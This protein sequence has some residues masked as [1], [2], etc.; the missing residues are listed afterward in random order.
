[1]DRA[2]VGASHIGIVVR[3][4]VRLLRVLRGVLQ[5]DWHLCVNARIK[6]LVRVQWAI[7]MALVWIMAYGNRTVGCCC[8]SWCWAAPTGGTPYITVPGIPASAAFAALVAQLAALGAVHPDGN[9]EIAAFQCVYKMPATEVQEQH[10][11]GY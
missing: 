10:W 1:M 5:F 11:V 2:V 4:Y 6:L 3:R 9:T 7:L 8:W